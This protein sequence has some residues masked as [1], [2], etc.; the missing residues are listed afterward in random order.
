MATVDGQEVDGHRVAGWQGLLEHG[1]ERAPDA[2]DMWR[3]TRRNQF[4]LGELT[5]VGEAITKQFGGKGA[6]EFKRWL[7]DSVGALTVSRPELITALHG[8]GAP[9]VTTNYD[10]LIEQVTK[11]QPLTWQGA[12]QRRR[13]VRLTTLACRLP[14]ASRERSWIV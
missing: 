3:D 13:S 14:A 4:D 7:R 6:G 8:L 10:D 11:L 5:A 2:P 9:L 12:V 1:V